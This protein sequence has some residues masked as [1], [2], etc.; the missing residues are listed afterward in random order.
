MKI[1]IIAEIAQAHDGSLGILHSYIDALSETGIDT[2]K[3]Q[4]HIAEAESS[5]QEKFRVNFSYEDQTRYDYWK[6]MGFDFE[7]WQ[8][9]KKHCE[10][11]KLNF[12][13][14]PF[15]I[16]AVEWL[17]NLNTERYKIASGETC[18]YLMLSKICSTGKL[19][20]LSSGMS[21]YSEIDESLEFIRKNN[22]IVSAIFQCT[23][24][25][26][27]PPEKIGLNIIT[28]M[29]QKYSLPVGLSDHS[30][31]IYPAIAAAAL[32]AEFIEFHAVFDKKMFGPDATSSLTIL[33]IK[34][35]VKGIRFIETARNS[36]IDKNETSQYE[37]LKDLFGKTLSSRRDLSIGHIIC[38]E[39]L[40]SKKP[41]KMGI[42]ACDYSG[43][44]GKKVT[45]N[46]N[47][48]EFLT[49]HHFN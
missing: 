21:S 35:A 33:E 10:E 24:S 8:Q 11:K 12:L 40:E 25:Y 48:N 37:Q 7:Q 41:G 31:S 2:V 14:S 34:D 32:G 27:T 6:R 20:L 23:T 45:K 18:N 49:Q 16:Q 26:P 42:P 17:E 28:E 47:K 39:D 43:I 46:I 15:S 5:A 30:G 22:G 29:I 44:I 36:I 13:C 9:I 38:F 19:I 1:E 4:M 3:F